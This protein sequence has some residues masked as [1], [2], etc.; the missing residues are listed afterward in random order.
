MIFFPFLTTRFV[1]TAKLRKDVSN[2]FSGEIKGWATLWTRNSY[3]R[4]SDNSGNPRTKI[5]VIIRSYFACLA[6]KLLK[7]MKLL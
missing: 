3:A 1:C 7:S 4:K 6:W 2:I 5:S